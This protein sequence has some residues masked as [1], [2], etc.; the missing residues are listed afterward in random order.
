M[1]TIEYV[2]HLSKEKI[3]EIIIFYKFHIIKNNFPKKNDC[4]DLRLV[5]LSFSFPL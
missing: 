5:I 1:N 2:C 4:H 3:K